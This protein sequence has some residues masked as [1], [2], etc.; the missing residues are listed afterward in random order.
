MS[1]RRATKL[2]DSDLC[3]KWLENQA[4]FNTKW[5]SSL[6]GTTFNLPNRNFRATL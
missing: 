2:I 1:N 4:F 3:E 6:Y 5:R